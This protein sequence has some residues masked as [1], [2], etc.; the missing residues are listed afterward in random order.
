MVAWD[1]SSD[2]RALGTHTR[3]HTLGLE[4]ACTAFSLPRSFFTP[5][6][7]LLWQVED[8]AQ[9]I[10]INFDDGM[11]DGADCMRKATRPRPLSPLSLVL[12]AQGKPP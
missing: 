10:D 2:S 4:Q 3:L 11:L 6:S 8:G 7:R 9:L 5:F 12:L 1:G